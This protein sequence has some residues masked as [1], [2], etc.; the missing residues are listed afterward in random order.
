MSRQVPVLQTLEPILSTLAQTGLMACDGIQAL[1]WLMGP[2]DICDT[3]PRSSECPTR[4]TCLHLVA[5][6]G[7]AADAHE[8]GRR[9]PI[10][11]GS[12][13]RVPVS[14]EPL[15]ARAGIAALGVAEAGWI[16][17]HRVRALAAMPLEQGERRIGMLAVLSRSAPPAEQVRLLAAAA[18]LG[19]EAIGNVSAFRALAAERN[20][21][22]A[23]SAR[24]RSGLPLAPEP[25][26]QPA[27]P[28]TGVPSPAPVAESRPPLHPDVTVPG[29]VRSFA[30][31]QRDGILRALERTGWRVSG[32][33]GAALLL[34]LKPTTLESKMKKLGLHR[35]PR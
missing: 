4:T 35:P 9:I 12:L 13:G 27:G 16:A 31:V 5:S 3:C 11:S 19:A 24:L 26:P 22:A 10:G 23:R 15:L 2:G 30:E 7:I 20:R 14:H 34:G 32:P 18:R 21:L 8:R 17:R 28:P 33:R 25:E 1:V 6:A 29:Q